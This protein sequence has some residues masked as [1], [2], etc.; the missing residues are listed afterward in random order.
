LLFLGVVRL[1]AVVGARGDSHPLMS[2]GQKNVN[3]VNRYAKGRHARAVSK[4][5]G[6][7]AAH[8]APFRKRLFPGG[9]SEAAQ[10]LRVLGRA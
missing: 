7:V 2:R 10:H 3:R 5:Y 9:S 8:V 4:F 6:F 1:F